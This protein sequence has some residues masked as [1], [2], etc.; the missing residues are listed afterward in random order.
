MKMKITDLMD[1]YAD[2]RSAGVLKEKDGGAQGAP[3]QNGEYS[4]GEV[5]EVKTSKHAFGWKE[6]LSLA[7]ALALVVLGGFGV[8]KLIDRSGP[9]IQA[10][11]SPVNADHSLS[12]P[13]TTE[14]EPDPTIV[15]GLTEAD[16]AEL[17][18][19]LSRIAEQGISDLDTELDEEY[20]LAQFAHICLKRH[21]DSL[22]PRIIYQSDETGTYET[23]GLNWV[24]AVLES[25]LDKTISPA[26][27]T[28]YTVLRGDNYAQ[29]ESFHDGFFWWP[30]ADGDTS[31]RFARCAD[32]TWVEDGQI[33]ASFVVYEADPAY[34]EQ[35]LSQDI[36]LDPGVELEDWV[37]N[38]LLGMDEAE[39]QAH[40]DAGEITPVQSG[41]ALL[42]SVT[43]DFRLLQYKA[44]AL[45][46]SSVPQ[47]APTKPADPE[48]EAAV[49]ALFEDSNGWYS[50]A[51]HSSFTDPARM[52]LRGFFYAGI[53][54]EEPITDAERAALLEAYPETADW[55]AGD[56]LR[57]PRQK[58]LEVLAQYFGLD[59]EQAEARIRAT[60]P[61]YLPQTDSFYFHV[62]DVNMTP[63]QVLEVRERED[64]TV[65]FT[66]RN[67]MWYGLFERNP[68]CTV[69]LQP[70]GSGRY[71]IRSNLLGEWATAERLGTLNA[72]YQGTMATLQTETTDS[73]GTKAVR[74]LTLDA[75]GHLSY[76]EGDPNSE[77]SIWN[78]GEWLLGDGNILYCR[79]YP[80][81]ESG[82]AIEPNYYASFRCSLSGTEETVFERYLSLVQ[83]S[84]QGFGNDPAGTE[85]SFVYYT[86]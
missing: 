37:W 73:D 9:P 64:G 1:L 57:L 19:L 58:M 24:N 30:A 15:N 28:D 17:N 14:T 23:V 83:Q 66:Y 27:G 60:Y 22:D 11:Q 21:E 84:E 39:A 10:S 79:I 40:I 6:A 71:L 48:T 62:S 41:S 47:E 34:L 81:D 56:W 31:T 67:E 42:K 12:D 7:A 76:R 78:R 46:P 85:L 51:L 3:L 25:M 53:P 86:K 82:N 2:E 74:E 63:R 45:A 54:G 43:S 26:E 70:D 32:W 29:H 36:T 8:K 49:R 35:Q 52:D 4:S 69:C 55:Y 33:K 68:I 38:Q 13:A 65:L 50:Q 59:A 16:Y 20:E 75:D 61:H 77:Y 44:E 18:R 80:A 72:L 5:T